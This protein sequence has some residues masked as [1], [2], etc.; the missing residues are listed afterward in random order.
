MSAARVNLREPYFACA[1]AS[2]ATVPG[3]PIE[4]AEWRDFSA[5]ASPLA[6]RKTSRVTAAGAV[7]R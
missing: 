1:S 4:S 5:S 6:S 2:P 3:T 7:S